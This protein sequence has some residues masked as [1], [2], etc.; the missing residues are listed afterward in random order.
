MTFMPLPKGA[1]GHFQ[2]E[3]HQRRAADAGL[4][5]S[6]ECEVRGPVNLSHAK[7]VSSKGVGAGARFLLREI[8]LQEL[9]LPLMT[10]DHLN[11]QREG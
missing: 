7:V 3:L 8:A 6:H 4:I 2:A 10:R 9:D 11:D 5:G 1:P